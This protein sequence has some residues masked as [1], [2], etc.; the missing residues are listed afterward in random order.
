MMAITALLTL[1]NR[2]FLAQFSDGRALRE[3]DL[4]VLADKLGE[5]GLTADDVHTL[6]WR[7]GEGA[8]MRGQIIAIKARM[9][10]RRNID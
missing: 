2:A 4:D 1:E 7:E 3:S 5:M 9:R 6:D 8:L 10:E